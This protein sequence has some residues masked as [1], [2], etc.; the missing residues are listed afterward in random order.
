M[1]PTVWQ[2]RDLTAN[3][4]SSNFS[5]LIENIRIEIEEY[6]DSPFLDALVLLSH[7]SGRTKSEIIAHPDLNLPAEQATQLT[8]SIKKIK[9]G[10]PLPYVLG[11]WEFF[12]L[13]FKVTPAVLIPRPESEWLVETGIRWYQ[14]NP[15]RRTCLDLGTGS[16]CLAIATAKSIPDLKITAIDVSHSALLVAQE[17]ARNHQV[18]EQIEFITSDLLKGASPKVDLAIANLPYIP[19]EKLK[20]LTV[21]GSEPRQAL[22]G[23]I[24]GLSYIRSFLEYIPDLINPDGLILLELDEEVGERAHALVCES[25]PRADIQLMQDLAGL[26]RYLRI[27]IP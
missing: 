20:G 17:N 22:D 8:S 23:G 3:N 24:D 10:V 27:L 19:T 7:I 11:K 25:L 12:G 4:T 2:K 1:K 9:A 21:Y 6:S 18:Q 26:D 5:S 15:S 14:E 16:G 13:Q